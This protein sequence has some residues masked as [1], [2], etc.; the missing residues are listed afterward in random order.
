MN[1]DLQKQADDTVDSLNNYEPRPREEP[2]KEVLSE[3]TVAAIQSQPFVVIPPDT[4]VLRAM[5]TLA[6][7]EIGCVL[8][9]EDDRLVGIF[10]QRDVLDRVAEQYEQVKDLPISEL[11]TS[12]LVAVYDS[13]PAAA[14]LCAMAA[15]GYRHVPVLNMNEE[16]VGIVGPQRVTA[17]LQQYLEDT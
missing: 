14:A 17:F 9:G 12:N 1:E 5:Q 4:P 15:G 10:T 16:I 3:E 2:L 11:M 13:D 8:V 6:G 7:L